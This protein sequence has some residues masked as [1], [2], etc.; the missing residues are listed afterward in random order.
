[1]IRNYYGA[2]AVCSLSLTLLS[3][4]LDR[5]VAEAGFTGNESIVLGARANPTH[6]S[7]KRSAIYQIY[8]TFDDGPSEG[9]RVV[10]Q[11]SLAD[12]LDINVFL[13]GDNA[14]RNRINRQILEEYR[15]NP[16]VE[17]GNHSFSHAGAHY[18][19]YFTDPASVVADFLRNRDSLGLK[20]DLL[21]LP[22]RNCFRVGG[23][24]KDDGNGKRAAD[25]LAGLGY[26][27]FGWDLEWRNEGSKGAYSGKEMYD[28]AQDMLTDHRTTSP[29]QLIILLHDRQV[30][31]PAF[32][33][34]LENFVRLIR[35]DG[36]FEFGHLS[37]Y[38]MTSDSR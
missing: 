8:L 4:S 29:G 25:S 27:I 6:V 12:S 22:G 18:H 11:F 2:V 33:T 13:I 1:M 30:S 36:R 26:K 35:A 3:S 21:R 20:N 15:D 19:A 16:F 14:C 7:H 32:R 38:P 34:E 23:L 17:I 37:E 31:R 28:K 10:D 24:V 5:R 9:S